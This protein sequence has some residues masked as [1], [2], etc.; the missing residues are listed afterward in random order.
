MKSISSQTASRRIIAFDVLRG[1][2]LAI[3]LVDHIELYPSLFDMFTGRG[4]LFVS[5]AEGFFF[6]SG[7]LVGMVYKRR[8]ALGMKFIF[9]KMWIRSAELYVLAAITTLGYA[10][11][12]VT[13]GKASIKYGL[14]NPVDWGNII[15]ETL[16]LRY[17]FG[18]A[19]FLMRFSILMFF[20][21]FGFYLLKRGWWKVLL[22][23]TAG[24]WFFRDQNFTM[25]WQ[26]LFMS[27][28][29]VGYYWS[30]ITTKV[31]ALPRSTQRLL[32]RSVMTA[33]AVT[34]SL[35]YASVY[36]LSYINERPESV[37]WSVRTFVGHVNVV[38]EQIWI[39]AEKW[40]LGPLRI[41]LFAL[42]FTALFLLVNKHYP[43]INR[44][45]RGVFEI[46]GRNSLFVY[47]LHSF[48]VFC[49]HMY[50]PYK[51]SLWHNF[52]VTAVAL[53]ALIWGTSLYEKA[54]RAHPRLGVNHLYSSLGGAGQS[55]IGSLTKKA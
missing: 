6:L 13:A 50:I 30:E 23:I 31:K 55:L 54:R 51:F 21:P 52:L 40:T 29:V 20:A 15:H 46:L 35:S 28:M 49:F 38:N 10:F 44:A 11:W 1:L 12:A 32:Y 45:T 9:K 39:Y 37:S 34:F 5:A 48:I 42:W 47:L 2:M 27:G 4:R 33:S 19:D 36:L 24:V 26:L 16:L 3:M 18:W 7:L 8:I 41:V 53:A 22:M 25:A 14:P 17:G 43:V